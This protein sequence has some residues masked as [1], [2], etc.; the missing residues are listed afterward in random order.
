MNSSENQSYDLISFLW[1][2]KNPLITVGIVALV[3]S[4]IVSLLMD[5]KFESTVTLYPA[6]TSSVTF[7]EVITEDQSVSK[8]G[9]NEE[10]EQM[11]QI[12][13]SSSIRSKIIDKFNLLKHYEI[14]LESK[15]INTDLTKTYLENI[16]FKRNNNGAVLITVLDKSPDTAALI[17]NEIASLFDN[18]KNAMIHERALTD[19]KIKK[20]KLDKIIAQMQNLRDTMSKLS[21][22]GVVTNDAYRAL[23]EGYVNSKDLE[24]KKS[25]KTKMNMTEK[26]GSLLKSFQV[27]VEFLSERLATMEASYEQAESDATSYLSHKFIV[28]KAYPAEKKAYPIRWLIVVLSTFSAVLLAIVGILVKNQIE[29]LKD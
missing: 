13:E 23:T 1:K 8:F 2:N 11:L 12:L 14:D 4:S 10:A 9:E 19:F 5:E 22:L 16:N 7:N 24:M 21:S 26:Y 29:L 27:K 18:T 3:A 20:E 25:F 6:K 17:A 15:Y 28:E